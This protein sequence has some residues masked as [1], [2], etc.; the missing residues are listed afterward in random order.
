VQ[1]LGLHWPV[2]DDV[3]GIGRP[4]L[5]DG[6]ELGSAARLKAVL[7]IGRLPAPDR[8]AASPVLPLKCYVSHAN[9]R[10]RFRPTGFNSPTL[11]GGIDLATP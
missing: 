10:Y 9:E 4:V 11:A 3:R 2:R 7:D 8:L 5:D 1:V 6:A